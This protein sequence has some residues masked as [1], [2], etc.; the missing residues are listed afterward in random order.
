MRT[1]VAHAPRY[2]QTDGTRRTG[3][4]VNRQFNTYQTRN[5]VQ[6]TGATAA[7]RS[8]HG[9]TPAYAADRASGGRRSRRL[10][11]AFPHPVGG[12]DSAPRTR[13]PLEHRS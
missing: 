6:T 11:S 12:G 2:A 4:S 13:L 3:L 1:R 10:Q 9:M 5:S 7:C 8:A